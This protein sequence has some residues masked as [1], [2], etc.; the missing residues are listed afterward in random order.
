MKF[1]VYKL[2][3]PECGKFYW[4]RTC[5]EFRY[6][7]KNPVGERFVGPHHNPEVQALLDS[8]FTAFFIR[9]GWCDSETQ[10]KLVEG[11]FLHKVWPTGEW[12]D[13]PW[14]LLNRT[15]KPVGF[16]TGEANP[17]FLPHNQEAC[18][19]RAVS[20]FQS[21]ESV[22]RRNQSLQTWRESPDYTH[23]CVGVK[24]PDLA[25]RNKTPEARVKASLTVSKTN[26]VLHE[27]PE[28][29]M[30]MNAG[31]LTKHLRSKHGWQSGL[32]ME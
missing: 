31:N 8:G 15:N 12:S 21:P 26:R 2:V 19:G 11:N 6:G 13:R 10:S 20:V 4:G 17:R 3:F 22:K 14:W 1:F 23:P 5:Q 18:R 9:T 29:G 24:R 32:P 7:R 30:K 16:A 25:E 27:C 28:C